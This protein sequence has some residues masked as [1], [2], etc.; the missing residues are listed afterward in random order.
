MEV[1]WVIGLKMS[2]TWKVLITFVSVFNSMFIR[3]TYFYYLHNIKKKKRRS[4][5]KK[6]YEMPPCAA[7]SFI[8]AISETRLAFLLC[9]SH[10]QWCFSVLGHEVDPEWHM[11]AQSLWSGILSESTLP[12]RCTARCPCRLSGGIRSQRSSYFSVPLVSW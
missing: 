9:S 2:W 8:V 6:E 11:W 3:Y 1:L 5:N 12:L 4:H 10:A 7:F